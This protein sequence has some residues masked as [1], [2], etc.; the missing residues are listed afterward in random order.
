MYY[1][2]YNLLEN[3][4]GISTD[5]KFLWLGEKHQEALSTLKFGLIEANGY[6]VLTGDAGTGKTTIVK[7]LIDSLDDHVLVATINHPTLK[8][9][10]FLNLVCRSY[11]FSAEITSKSEFL[12]LFTAFLQKSK[13]EG[14]VVLLVI[15]EAHLLS[16]E[17]LEEIR[18]LSNIEQ[19]GSSLVRIFFVGQNELKQVLFTPECRAIRQRITLFYEIEP[20]L[21]DETKLY[22]DHRLRIAGGDSSIFTSSALEEI[23]RFTHGYPRLINT[24]CSHALLTGFI[25]ELNEIDE[26][27]IDEITKEIKFLDPKTSPTL[28]TRK[29]NFWGW[30]KHVIEKS[31]NKKEYS[32]NQQSKDNKISYK[33]WIVG[34]TGFLALI[35]VAVGLTNR[36]W[37]PDSD[38][39]SVKFNNA[40]ITDEAEKSVGQNNQVIQPLPTQSSD[41]P[42]PASEATFHPTPL[43]SATY[44]EK[45]PFDQV[46]KR[47]QP[48]SKLTSSLVTTN[49]PQAEEEISVAGE[50]GIS[51]SQITL[52]ALASEAVEQNNF[53]RAIDLLKNEKFDD[54]ENFVKPLEIYAKALVGR[55]EQILITSPDESE[56]LLLKS[57]EI[58]P[59]NSS[60]HLNLGSL[61]LKKKKY[62]SAIDAFQQAAAVN[63]YLS[64]AFFNL[65]FIYA[66]TGN[67]VEAE[68]NFTQAVKLKPSYLDK[69][70]FNLAL[71]QEKRGKIEECVENLRLSLTINPDNERVQQYLKQLVKN[72][73]EEIDEGL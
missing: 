33:R 19:A 49:F 43:A 72:P 50:S 53:Q 47:L 30:S 23:Q 55:A 62:T 64:K 6:V 11:D 18:L 8:I 44:E 28:P 14:K 41:P 48:V 10:D 65:G 16:V 7:A 67:Y 46:N 17:L 61:Y 57:I 60:A 3:P 39:A 9:F 69:A 31:L 70:L 63:P 37:V 32:K 42:V 4:F 21:K 40:G 2:F 59:D 22:I 15:D 13:D 35:S 5:P 66:T 71:V 12:S 29:E 73:E 27:I 24:L 36:T 38:P 20:L 51:N 52:L 26:I 68:K 58:D 25:R 1:S 56:N 34:A 45:E 54:N